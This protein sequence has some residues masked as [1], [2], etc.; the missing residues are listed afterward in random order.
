[1]RR[2]SALILAA[3]ALTGCRKDKAPVPQAVAPAPAAPEPAS[4]SLTGRILERI[5]AAPYSYLRLQRGKEELWAAVPQTTAGKGDEVTVYNAMEMDAFE[6]KTLKRKFDVIYFGTL[7]PP[8]PKGLPAGMASQHA[9]AAKGPEE[10]ADVKVDK[11]TGPEARTVAEAH[12]QRA[13]L[14][15]KV[16]AIRGKVV[17]FTPEVMGKNW[18]HLRDGSGS[19]AAGDNDIT[20]TTKDTVKLG[21]VV[22]VKGTVHINRDFGAGY[23]YE[24][25]IEDAKVAK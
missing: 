10:T 15:G 5:D 9:A 2:F 24:V 22:L 13:A 11:A 21:D 7:T 4:A 14:D 20:V 18:L 3:A 1:M 25:I 17:K 19:P 8:A 16:V 12:A 6:S 23:T